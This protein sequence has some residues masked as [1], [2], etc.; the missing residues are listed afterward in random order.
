PIPHSEFRTPHFEAGGEMKRAAF[1]VARALDPDPAAHHLNEL[2][3][4]RQP[5]PSAAILARR[6]GIR[7]LE[8]LEDALLLLGRDAD[9]RVGDGEME[10]DPVLRDGR[11]LMVDG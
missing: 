4:D 5:Q 2:R 8:G 11:W 1:A 10:D 9:P 3:R 7:L 6:G